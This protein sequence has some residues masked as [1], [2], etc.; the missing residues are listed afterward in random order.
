MKNYENENRDTKYINIIHYLVFVLLL[1]VANPDPE[2]DPI[3]SGYFGGIRF[4]KVAGFGSSTNN[5][6]IKNTS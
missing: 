1:R 5:M 3:G 4:L 2:P 6:E